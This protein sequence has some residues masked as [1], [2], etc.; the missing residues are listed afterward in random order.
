VEGLEHTA[1]TPWSLCKLVGGEPGDAQ[2]VVKLSP[3]HIR[4]TPTT[5]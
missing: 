3:P 2:C 5:G 1:E 4:L